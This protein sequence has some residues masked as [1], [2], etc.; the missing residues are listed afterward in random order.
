MIETDKSKIEHDKAKFYN[1]HVNLNPDYGKKKNHGFSSGLKSP[2][3][4]LDLV[5]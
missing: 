2:T 4:E 1:F 3:A 5:H